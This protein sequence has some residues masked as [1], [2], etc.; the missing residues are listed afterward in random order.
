MLLIST[1]SGMASLGTYPDSTSN[2]VD[3]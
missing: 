3:S 1:S 2:L